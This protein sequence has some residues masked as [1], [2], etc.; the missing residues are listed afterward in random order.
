MDIFGSLIS[1]FHFL[2]KDVY[3]LDV[4]DQYALKTEQ[5]KESQESFLDS[6]IRYYHWW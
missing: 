5:R 1:T 6:D 3:S 4:T 2:G